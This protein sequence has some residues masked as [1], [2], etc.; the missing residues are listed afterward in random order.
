MAEKN[1]ILYDSKLVFNALFKKKKKAV[2]SARAGKWIK[3]E[4]IK[5]LSQFLQNRPPV[6]FAC[7]DTFLR[8]PTLL[9]LLLE[10]VCVRACT[11]THVCGCTK[12]ADYVKELHSWVLQ[13]LRST[14]RI[15]EQ[16]TGRVLM[17]WRG[18]AA[19]NTSAVT[20]ACGVRTSSFLDWKE[21]KK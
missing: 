12:N 4:R 15:A 5:R 16:I 14:Y 3:V 9:L 19:Q 10:E 7:L 13:L 8:R 18:M 20:L 6:V 17:S 11:C 21:R 2:T 1:C